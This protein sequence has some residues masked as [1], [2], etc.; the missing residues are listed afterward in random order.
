[1]QGMFEKDETELEPL[2]GPVN[3]AHQF[4]DMPKYTVE[5][6][7]PENGP[8]TVQIILNILWKINLN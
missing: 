7:D 5:V 8:T 1:M 6:D 4:V 2:E 3:F